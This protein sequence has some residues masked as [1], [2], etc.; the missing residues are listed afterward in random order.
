M[1]NSELKIYFEGGF[2]SV[3]KDLRD[4]KK[5][6]E[7]IEEEIHDLGNGKGAGRLKGKQKELG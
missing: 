7:K 2:Q 4:V 5:R 3:K 6:L 1:S